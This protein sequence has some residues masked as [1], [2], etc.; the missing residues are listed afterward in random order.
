[1]REHQAR[2]LSKQDLNEDQS[3]ASD[4]AIIR[5]SGL[6]SV[7]GAEDPN[8]NANPQT[9]KTPAAMVWNQFADAYKLNEEETSDGN[10]KKW[11]MDGRSGG[12]MPMIPR[13]RK[14]EP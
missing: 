3:Q 12:M 1:M 11:K 7:V 4:S 5:E 2:I 13:W 8:L 9:V 10:K 14:A 6:R